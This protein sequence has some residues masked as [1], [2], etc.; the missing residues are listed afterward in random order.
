MVAT[1]YRRRSPSKSLIAVALGALAAL[2]L[3]CVGDPGVPINITTVPRYGVN[4][5]DFKP[6]SGV[7]ERRCGNLDCHGS[8]YRAMKIYGK[9]GLRHL[10]LNEMGFETT[11]KMD[12]DSYYSGG[13]E[14]TLAELSDNYDSVI[15][16]E[17]V[18]L[19]EV[20]GR[21][22]KA[23]VAATAD[24]IP[25]PYSDAPSDTMDVEC[26]TLIRKPRLQEKH[27]GGR[28]WSTTDDGD[29]CLKLWILNNNEYLERCG[30]DIAAFNSG[31]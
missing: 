18:L 25:C 16:L 31:M 7:L 3:G 15:S 13:T 29:K 4:G 6:V 10:E 14:T 23:Q 11:T 21:K 5:E 30:N 22:T 26:L 20:F 12:Y 8:Q 19:Q 1:Y 9:Y 24:G 28:I 2:T 27:K 17:P